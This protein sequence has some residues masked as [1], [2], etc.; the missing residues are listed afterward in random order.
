LSA[1][2][3][4]CKLDSKPA[5]H[6]TDDTAHILASS[7]A[8]AS[9]ACLSSASSYLA[10]PYA[11]VIAPYRRPAMLL[12]LRKC[13]RL[14][15]NAEATLASAVSQL[16]ALFSPGLML[17]VQA[18]EMLDRCPQLAA[19]TATS[20]KVMVWCSTPLFLQGCFT[21]MEWG[22]AGQ[23]ASVCRVA[24]V[25]LLLVRSPHTKFRVGTLVL[26]LLL[27]GAL[28][29]KQHVSYTR[30][31]PACCCSCCTAALMKELPPYY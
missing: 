23:A 26:G 1:W 29:D 11:A 15:N 28:Q 18:H 16:L 9:A 8:A 22:L 30:G 2:G 5:A 27:Q 19:R 13:P 10:F 17:P 24:C 3:V 21:S 4:P 20:T 25:I 12:W 31:T 6:P 7:S 14:L